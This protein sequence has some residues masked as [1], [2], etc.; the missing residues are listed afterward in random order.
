MHCCDSRVLH[1][2]DNNV[3]NDNI[4]ERLVLPIFN[5][6]LQEKIE[7]TNF[8]ITKNKKESDHKTTFHGRTPTTY[9]YRQ[10]IIR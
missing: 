7:I 9:V 10:N 5:W 8:E 3:P 6:Q 1:S 4:H 2:T